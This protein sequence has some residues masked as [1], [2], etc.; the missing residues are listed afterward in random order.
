M[1]SQIPSY[2]LFFQAIHILGDAKNGPSSQELSKL[3]LKAR[4]LLTIPVTTSDARLGIG[5]SVAANGSKETDRLAWNAGIETLRAKPLAFTKIVVGALSEYLLYAPGSITFDLRSYDQRWSESEGGI[6]AVDA[7]R[8]A[9]SERFGGDPTFP[10]ASLFEHRL[11]SLSNVM[12]GLPTISVVPPSWLITT[13]AIVAILLAAW[14]KTPVCPSL[15]A[16]IYFLGCVALASISQGY[17][18]RYF[19]TASLPLFVTFTIDISRR[20]FRLRKRE[21]LY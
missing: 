6:R 10:V 14:S 2:F 19:L 11:S 15:I 9:S 7:Y 4:S 16:A 3:G 1:P 18:V 12:G 21:A 13:I 5:P 8:A 17:I 20:L